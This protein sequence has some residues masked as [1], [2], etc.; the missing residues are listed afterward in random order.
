MVKLTVFVGFLVVLTA[1]T[2]GWACYENARSL[3]LKT[4]LPEAAQ[5][6]DD[7]RGITPSPGNAWS[8]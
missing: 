3:M 1:G 8:R 5:A 4:G 7:L 6:A 2:L